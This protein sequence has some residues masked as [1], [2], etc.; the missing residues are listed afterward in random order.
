MGTPAVTP[1]AVAP[2]V[3]PMSITPVTVAPVFAE[4]VKVTTIASTERNTG[5]YGPHSKSLHCSNHVFI[6]ERLYACVGVCVGG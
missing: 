6:T 4:P 3:T 1:V 2:V 5:P